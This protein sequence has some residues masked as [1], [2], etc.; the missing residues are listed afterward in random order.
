MGAM[1]G[2]APATVDAARP[3]PARRPRRR[4][5]LLAVLVVSVLLGTALMVVR[6]WGGGTQAA[7]PVLPSVPA[8]PVSTVVSGVYCGGTNVSCVQS[9]EQFRGRPVAIVGSFLPQASWADIEVPGW[10]PA[11]WAGT[12]YQQHLLVTV[13]ML[14]NLSW[15]NLQDGAKGNYDAYFKETARHLV[16]AGLGSSWVRVGHEL[17]GTWYRWSAQK[18]PAA[19]AEYYRHIITAMRSVPGQSFK[20]DWNVAVGGDLHMDATKAYPGDEYVDAIGQDVYDQKWNAPG[21]SA[22]DRWRSLVAPVGATA[23]GLEFWATFATQHGKP[24]A[25]GEWGLVGEGSQMAHGGAGGDSPSYIDHMHQW[26]ATHNTAYEIYF[27]RDAPDGSH[28]ID[29]GAFPQSAARY[30]ELF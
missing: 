24:V 14:P 9:F 7:L 21:A 12:A 17:N 15:T 23:Q 22:D 25:F 27:N 28:R 2:N 3:A 10:W 20:F 5:A 8:E 13:P 11:I 18:D 19:Y 6:P 29:G 16:E 26:F 4:R 1:A 30:A